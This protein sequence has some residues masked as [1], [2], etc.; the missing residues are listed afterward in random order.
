MTASVAVVRSWK[1]GRYTCTLSVP[2]GKALCASVEWEPSM[3]K[4]LN[5]AEL[6]AYTAGRNRAVAQIAAELGVPSVIVEL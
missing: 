1:V 4:T 2:A 6:A 5:A 3:P